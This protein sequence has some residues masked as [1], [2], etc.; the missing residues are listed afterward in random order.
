MKKRFVLCCFAVWFHIFAE[1]NYFDFSFLEIRDSSGCQ[2][3]TATAKLHA[4][5]ENVWSAITDFE[6]YGEF[7]PR[8]SN[9]TVLQSTADSMAVGINLDIPWPASDIYYEIKII[10]RQNHLFF[11]WDNIRGDLEV[12]RGYWLI[13]N[14]GENT[15]QLTYHVCVKLK[16]ILPNFMVQFAQ[17]ITTKN[18]IIAVA[19][20]ATN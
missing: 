10:P 15:I 8:V 13:E 7:M 11:R 9:C 14:I 17:Q 19:E 5:S 1:D 18:L 3:V 20:R 12:N 16:T 4:T 6:H 2:I